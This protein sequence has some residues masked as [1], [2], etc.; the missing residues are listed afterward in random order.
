MSRNLSRAFPKAEKGDA[1]SNKRSR[2][3]GVEDDDLLGPKR[4][5][6]LPIHT[7]PARL[8]FPQTFPDQNL[9]KSNLQGGVEKLLAQQREGLPKQRLVDPE[10]KPSSSQVYTPFATFSATASSISPR[11]AG[12]NEHSL[13]DKSSRN[14]SASVALEDPESSDSDRPLLHRR[15]VQIARVEDK[16]LRHMKKEESINPEGIQNTPLGKPYHCFRSGLRTTSAVFPDGYGLEASNQYAAKYEW[17]CSVRNCRQLFATL[18]GLNIHFLLA[19]EALRLN[20]NMDGTVSIVGGRNEM[21][22]PKSIIV[23]Q[24]PAPTSLAMAEPSLSQPLLSIHLKD[25]ASVTNGNL[26]TTHRNSQNGKQSPPPINSDVAGG[27]SKDLDP[28]RSAL[29]KVQA[30]SGLW[31][32]V[33][34]FLPHNFMENLAN[35]ANELELQALTQILSYQLRYNLKA[36]WVTKMLNR[37]K[38][39]AVTVIAILVRA[40]SDTKSVCDNCSEKP[41]RSRCCSSRHGILPEHEALKQMISGKCCYCVLFGTE[42]RTQTKIA[43][44]PFQ[45]ATQNQIQESSSNNRLS[46]NSGKPRDNPVVLP[47][48]PERCGKLNLSP[49][50][51]STHDLPDAGISLLPS[52]LAPLPHTVPGSMGGEAS[53]GS[54][55]IQ[56]TFGSIMRR[57]VDLGMNIQLLEQHDRSGVLQWVTIVFSTPHLEAVQRLLELVAVCHKA[58]LQMQQEIIQACMVAL[59]AV[60]PEVTPAEWMTAILTT[61]GIPSE[62]ERDVLNLVTAMRKVRPGDQHGLGQRVLSTLS[63]YL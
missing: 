60:F 32:H 5:A 50:Q 20:D 30:T 33:N 61:Q 46:T 4:R 54:S 45:P 1:Q 25:L 58:P 22:E 17:I 52:H 34:P 47:S 31:N 16:G 2:P 42:C 59:K 29:K 35:G 57:A 48:S 44:N 12:R 9:S 37:K 13:A 26:S 36:D 8:D 51:I 21:H 19:H 27:S 62:I 3:P 39:R 53:I 41:D 24:Y 49:N 40:I 38:R 18:Q 63:A 55:G 14:V 28:L 7:Q 6:G 10:L 15:G 56:A 23:S 11:R 43:D